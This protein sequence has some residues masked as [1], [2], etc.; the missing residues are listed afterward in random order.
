MGP[1]MA[2]EIRTIPPRRHDDTAAVECFRAVNEWEWVSHGKHGTR[3]RAGSERG[4]EKSDRCRAV[5]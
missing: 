1:G 2:H 3:E 5:K 4:E